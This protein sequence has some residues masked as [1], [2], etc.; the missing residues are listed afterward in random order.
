M[1]DLM[2]LFIDESIDE[3]SNRSALN[4]MRFSPNYL[5]T[6]YHS[7]NRKNNETM[8][9]YIFPVLRYHSRW[10][11]LS[12]VDFN[13][14]PQ[15]DRAKGFDMRS[16]AICNVK[17]KEE[18]FPFFKQAPTDKA[19]DIVGNSAAYIR[20]MA[21]LCEDNGAEM[22][23]IKTPVAAYTY[24]MGNAM[25]QFAG[26]CGVELIDYNQ[27]WKDL[28]L[29]YTADFL[30]PVHLNLNG[31]EKLSKSLGKTLSA[32]FELED[33]RG[34]TEYGTWNED[35]KMYEA[36]KEAKQLQNSNEISDYKNLIKKDNYVILYSGNITN[37]DD[38]FRT[39]LGLLPAEKG[40]VQYGVTETGNKGQS[41]HYTGTG[42]FRHDIGNVRCEVGTAD[43]YKIRFLGEDV[44]KGEDGFYLVVF[45]KRLKL[46]ADVIKISAGKI[47]AHLD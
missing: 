8:A 40:A 41:M 46:A 23:F 5:T 31:A 4:Y 22:L 14:A 25:K 19:A 45:D 42:K 34:E 1:F 37:V 18:D 10:E 47:V 36:E 33:H 38:S 21:D 17:L 9:S 29:D 43:G 27:K 12:T 30:D 39:Q 32:E 16:G 2:S 15:H 3:I 24:E 11:E 44:T 13:I 35:Y 6:V 26:E 20:D 7:L 28:N